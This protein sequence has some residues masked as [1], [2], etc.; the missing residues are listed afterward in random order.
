MSGLLNRSKLEDLYFE[1]EIGFVDT[2][3]RNPKIYQDIAMMV[4]TSKSVKRYKW[5]HTNPEM[6]RWVGERQIE[7]L[8]AD[9]H[10]IESVKYGIGIEVERD[11]MEDDE[12]FGMIQG[13]INGLAMSALRAIEKAVVRAYTDGFNANST[14]CYDGQPLFDAGHTMR[15]DGSGEQQSNM[16]T[17]ALSQAS[18]EQAYQMAIDFRD[19]KGE[20]LD[21]RPKILLHGPGDWATARSILEAERINGGD[22]NLNQNLVRP[23]MSSYIRNGEWFLISESGG[24]APVILQM[25]Q[26]PVLRAPVT[27]LNDFEAYRSDVFHYGTDAKF[28]V[29]PAAW[30]LAIGSNGTT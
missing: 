23:V 28:G 17:A 20:G 4:R 14:L 7:K 30:Q 1:H 9:S 8:S 10:T 26:E 15:G 27:N 5:L 13:R 16:L 22:S 24:M 2:L 25:K 18:F 12:G 21:V 29:S 6:V 3:E 11:D 19:D